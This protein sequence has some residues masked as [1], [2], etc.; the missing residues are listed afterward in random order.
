M[1]FA[2]ELYFDGRADTVIR[3]DWEKLAKIGVTSAMLK[4]GYRPHITLGVSD[5]IAESTLL[6]WLNQFVHTVLPFSLTISYVG[7]FP[8]DE[9]VV[10]YGVTVTETLVDLHNRFWAGYEKL[11]R[12][13]WDDYRPGS[14]VPHCTLGYGLSTSQISKAVS[15]CRE[16]SLPIRLQ[17]ESLGLVRVSPSGAEELFMNKLGE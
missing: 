17:V 3:Q 9:G 11:V 7:A 5:E 2:V 14:W 16:L 10:F 8:G 15:T 6:E 13:S 1:V 12:K 4:P